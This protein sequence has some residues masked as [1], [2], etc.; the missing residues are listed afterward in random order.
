MNECGTIEQRKTTT[1]F[2]AMTRVEERF[3]QLKKDLGV[4]KRE[5]HITNAARPT[6]YDFSSLLLL[7]RLQQF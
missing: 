1:H 4:A 6:P 2:T 7:A 3:R 5:R